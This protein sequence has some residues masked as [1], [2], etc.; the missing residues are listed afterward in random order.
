MQLEHIQVKFIVKMQQHL[1]YKYYSKVQSIKVI[2]FKF[3]DFLTEKLKAIDDAL[4][5]DTF[6]D[7]FDISTV[8]I[9]AT[10]KK[11]KSK[12]SINRYS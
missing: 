12:Y 10:T 1:P 6:S 11:R 8:N 2:I 9:S 5:K 3:F 7:E 4:E